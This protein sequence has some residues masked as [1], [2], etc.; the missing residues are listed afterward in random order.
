MDERT[1]KFLLTRWTVQ[2]GE[3]LAVVHAINE[4]IA[5]LAEFAGSSTGELLERVNA[6]K[7][8]VEVVAPAAIED[9]E[10]RVE[11]MTADE[12][13]EIDKLIARVDVLEGKI[14]AVQ[15]LFGLSH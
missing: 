6:C 8:K 2:T 1:R 12:T 10:T 4:L 11:A 14:E 7:D 15:D 3:Q 5:K 9:L 13:G